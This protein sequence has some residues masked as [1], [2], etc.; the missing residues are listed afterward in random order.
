M[1]KKLKRKFIFLS[2]TALLTLLVVIVM[3]MNVINYN[4][5]VADADQV[6]SMLT[7]NGGRFPQMPGG[8]RDELGG[9]PMSPEIPFESRFFTVQFDT[10]GSVVFAD[11]GQIAAID[12]NMAIAYGK[13]IV[14]KEQKSGFMGNFRYVKATD[15][16][17]TRTIFLDCGRKLDAFYSFLWTSLFVSLLGY[18]VIGVFIVFFAGK[19]LRPVAQSY[20]KQKRFITDAGHEMKTPLTIIGANADV[21]L[22]EQ[23]ENDS[24]RDIKQQTNRLA[25]LTNDLVYLSRMEEVEN[26]LTMIE[27][28]VSDLVSETVHSFELVAQA[29][30]K[31]IL[32]DIQPMLT[33]NGDAK[34]IEKLVSII[35]S[36]AVKYTPAGGEIHLQLRQKGKQLLLT[37]ENP[38]GGTITP[39]ETAAVFDRFYRTD[40]SRNSQ[41]GG[42]GIGLSIAMAIVTAHGGKISAWTKDGK[43]FGITAALPAGT[44]PTLR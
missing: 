2:M 11:V 43:T 42:H 24:I 20:E 8:G 34:S 17:G 37:A 14:H 39:E 33:M 15:N 44:N 30:D 18:L 40:A 35:M 3:G 41:T 9:R 13:K 38:V 32:A 26:A 5:V 6:L 27:F 23:G 16:R 19:I 28:P 25:S 7:D 29:T 22:M 1:I 4:T 36:N 21:L 12:R 10:E 31:T